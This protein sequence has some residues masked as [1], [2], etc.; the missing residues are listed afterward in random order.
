MCLAI[1][2]FLITYVCGCVHFSAG[3][4]GGQ[5]CGIH[6]PGAGVTSSC[7]LLD[8]GAKL[9]FSANDACAFNG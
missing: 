6:L 7:D 9:E 3:A 2:L 8:I 5:R 1:E 4:Y